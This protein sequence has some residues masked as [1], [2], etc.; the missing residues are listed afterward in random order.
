MEYC[1]GIVLHVLEFEWHISFVARLV[2]H[3]QMKP[4]LST[5]FL[6]SPSL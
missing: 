6:T 2:M 4:S 3:Y 5:T 1:I